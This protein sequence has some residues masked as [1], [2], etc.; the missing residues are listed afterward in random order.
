MAIDLRETP[1]GGTPP[2]VLIEE[3]DPAVRWAESELLKR[4]GYDV[5][6]CAGPDDLPRGVCPLVRDGHC[7]LAENADVIVHNL[8]Q[9]LLGNR[10]VLDALREHVPDTPVIVEATQPEMRDD[11]DRFAGT[12]VV[13]FPVSSSSLRSAVAGALDASVNAE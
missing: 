4:D 5:V 12:I 11:P 2:L 3:S 9:R 7:D 8:R 1:G 13:R 10:Q 6:T